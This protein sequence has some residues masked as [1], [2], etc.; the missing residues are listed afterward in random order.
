MAAVFGITTLRPSSALNAVML[1]SFAARPAEQLI[2]RL[3][4][5]DDELSP[6]DRR[7]PGLAVLRRPAFLPYPHLQCTQ[8]VLQWLVY[9]L[10]HFAHARWVGQLDS[11]SWFDPHRL[12]SYLGA[13]EARLPA[14]ALVWAGLFEHWQRLRTNGTLECV[15]FSYDSPGAVVAWPER[16][17]ARARLPEEARR[18]ESFAMAQGG[19]YFFSRGAAAELMRHVHR[20]RDATSADGLR[21]L[22]TPPAA[23]GRQ[24][25]RQAGEYR[26]PPDPCDAIVGWLGARAFEGKALFAVGLHLNLEYHTFPVFTRYNP[27]HALLVH[28][29]KAGP[30]LQRT[31]D[32]YEQRNRN[33]TPPVTPRFTCV[34]TWWLHSRSRG[35]KLCY[36]TAPCGDGETE[37]AP[38]LLPRMVAGKPTNETAPWFPVG[39]RTLCAR[40]R[41]A[42]QLA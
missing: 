12:L 2:L 7:L 5:F 36:N 39:V 14:D 21:V 40:A 32:F 34:P 24:K 29:V 10:H 18:R 1:R 6:S 42:R 37:S 31:V 35:W 16:D 19:F 30:A 9:A 13:L 20:V 38:L 27:A 26:P 3:V 15:G 23:D 41:T 22:S 11:D 33:A 28:H 4:V 17:P 25:K 8:K